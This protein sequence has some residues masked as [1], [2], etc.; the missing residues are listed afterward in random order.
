[1]NIITLK[2]QPQYI[3]KAFTYFCDRLGRK[4]ADMIDSGMLMDGAMSCD[5]LPQWFLLM[6]DEEIAGCAGLVTD[7]LD[8]RTDLCPWLVLLFVEDR[9]RGNGY[10]KKLLNEVRNKARAMGYDKLYVSGDNSSYYEHLGFRRINEQ[11]SRDG[12]MRDIYA[13]NL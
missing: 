5:T 12:V 11:I 10:G 7:S 3:D 4:Y 6:D 2:I 8:V 1:M 9:Y 13:I